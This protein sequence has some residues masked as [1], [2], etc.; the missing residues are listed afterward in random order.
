MLKGATVTATGNRV[1]VVSLILPPGQESGEHEAKCF[2]LA[3]KVGCKSA[4]GGTTHWKAEGGGKLE[5]LV[6]IFLTY[7]L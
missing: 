6:M 3:S 1:S 5:L 4:V 2:F 7:V